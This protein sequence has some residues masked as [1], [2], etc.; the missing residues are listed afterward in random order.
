[1]IWL[2]NNIGDIR[3][4]IVLF[5]I[6]RLYAITDPPLE[7]AHNWRQT[8]VTM[9]AR[10]FYEA[11]NHIL[12]PRIDI[13]GEKWGITG[14]EFPV[15]NYLIYLVSLVFGYAHW[16]GRLINLVI[17]SFGI[18]YFYKLA[19]KYFGYKIAF[20]AAFLLIFSVWFNYSR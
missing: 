10:N 8:T 1:M 19:Y 2:T 20:N 18:F 9:A 13:A 3:L 14:M 7:V 17:S 6:V 15:L 12:Y 5:F 4:W 11:D 16:Y